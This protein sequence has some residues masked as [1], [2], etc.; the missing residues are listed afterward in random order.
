MIFAMLY[1]SINA[2]VELQ[3]DGTSSLLWPFADSWYISP[4]EG[5]NGWTYTSRSIYHLEGDVLA[6]DW[7]I[8]GCIGL[9]TC[10]RPL[11]AVFDATVL[12]TGGSQDGY[13]NQILLQ[14]TDN[15]DFVLRYAHLERIDLPRTDTIKAGSIIGTVGDTGNGDCHLHIVLYK[16]ML[17]QMP[18]KP[19]GY[20]YLNDVLENLSYRPRFVQIAAPFNLGAELGSKGV[21][22]E[23]FLEPELFLEDKPTIEG[24]VTNKSDEPIDNLQI[25]CT[26]TEL[27]SEKQETFTI[28]LS[29]PPLS[30]Q[31]FQF[32]DVLVQEGQYDIQLTY[33]YLRNGTRCGNSEIF[34]REVSIWSS[35]LCQS[36]EPNDE[37]TQAIPL[38]VNWSE[39]TFSLRSYLEYENREEDPD[40]F[41]LFFPQDG[42]LRLQ[43]IT[44]VRLPQ[45]L[46]IQFQ[47]GLEQF[48]VEDLKEGIAVK[49]G[50]S[51]LVHIAETRYYG[52]VCNSYQLDFEW[53]ALR[54]YNIIPNP[55]RGRFRIDVDQVR[56]D[57]AL[58]LYNAQGRLMLKTI[59]ASD[60]QGELWFDQPMAA[61]MYFLKVGEEATMK[62]L[63]F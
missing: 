43:Q 7:Y 19:D 4:I 3:A 29:L 45:L 34:Q 51:A 61:G 38:E 48:G 35:E 47:L 36:D 16:N 20:T 28:E 55:N 53:E 57:Y 31:E 33:G 1:S 58:T 59:Q 17:T 30:T 32:E 54:E 40:Y 49:A 56:S 39:K 63:V 25:F 37:A 11:R 24:T 22:I 44:D 10:G 6:Q 62:L 60:E 27:G 46:S 15:P 26:R 2:Q 5:S 41:S 50:S 18:G 52:Q 42:R 13:G 14:S 21:V 9:S 12:A 8:N 23:S